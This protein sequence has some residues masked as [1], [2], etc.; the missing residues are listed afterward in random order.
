[1]LPPLLL[2]RAVSFGP[3]MAHCPGERRKREE[4]GER[5]R[6]ERGERRERFMEGEEFSVRTT[7]QEMWPGLSEVNLEDLILESRPLQKMH[8]QRER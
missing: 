8:L 4:R 5:W 2:A 3:T 7:T 6:E 1:M